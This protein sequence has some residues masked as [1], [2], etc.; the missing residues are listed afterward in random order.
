[1]SKRNHRPM[2]GRI[3][4]GIAAAA[5]AGPIAVRESVAVA[6]PVRTA[7]HEAA[8]VVAGPQ[9]GPGRLLI[10]LIRPGWSL[11]NV[12]Y[13]EAVLRRDGAKAW[14]QGT[15]CFIDHDTDAE[16]DARPAGSIKNLAAVFTEDARWDDHQKALVAEVRLFAPWREA[17]TDMASHI[18]MS[19]RAWAHAEDSEAE[20]RYGVVLTSIVEGRSV[21]F[22]TV[23][24]AG[25][26]IVS[27]LESARK[28][29]EA[30]SLGAWL[31]SR[32][33]LALTTL[34]DDM[35]GDGRL[36]RE[37]RITLSSAIGDGL[38]AWT[39]RV[40]ADAPQLFQRDLYD[41]P[42]AAVEVPVVEA[43]TSSTAPVDDQTEP[44]SDPTPETS[45]PTTPAAGTVTDGAPPTA[46]HP[47]S[48]EEPAMSGTQTGAPPVQA[49]TATVVEPP[50]IQPTLSAEARA[51]V[52]EARLAEA[53]ARI[54]T[55]EQSTVVLT[56]ERDQARNELRQTRHAEA[57]RSA[58]GTAL[59][60]TDLP[61]PAR[62]RIIESVT[63]RVPTTE[64]GDVDTQALSARITAAVETERQY[65]AAVRESQG[66]GTPT[67]L[68]G[69]TP[70][71]ESAGNAEAFQ[72]DIAARFT[73]LG[74]DDK[75]AALAARR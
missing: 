20:G 56:G 68:G 44:A 50:T 48:E 40:E 34:A 38:S 39:A 73:R 54:Q 13:P 5:A 11:N 47:P 33:H 7:V 51:A 12:Y 19:I 2:G 15:L 22:V 72:A 16:E 43:D 4:P 75:T 9:P 17:I 35:Y 61:A 52:A 63:G 67:G 28:V 10:R 37:E 62:A 32:L 55:L 31:E 60:A 41:E 70:A 59:D 24:A 69:T 46:P 29:E 3:R 25:G 23:P 21:D 57:A 6:A 8:G 18:G 27:V 26:G 58:C 1:M 36:T 30:R 49:G 74:Y 66:A 42:Q 65:I 14:P 53:N 64:G 71:V 45:Q